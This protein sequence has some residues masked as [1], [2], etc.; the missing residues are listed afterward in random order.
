[1]AEIVNFFPR[2]TL[3]FSASATYYS[4]IF[5]T[6]NLPTLVLEARLYY[7]SPAGVSIS[8]VVEETADPT[9]VRWTD[10]GSPQLLTSAGDR[11][12]FTLSGALRFVRVN[13]VAT[14]SPTVATLEVIGTA[15]A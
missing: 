2:Q 8:V 6:T 4:E 10:L 9:L 1:M 5:D 15:S 13:L 14:G 7:E 11:K 12:K 3:V